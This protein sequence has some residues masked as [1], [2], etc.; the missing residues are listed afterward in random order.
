MSMANPNVTKSPPR[1][2]SP[3]LGSSASPRSGE[4]AA[5]APA[6]TVMSSLAESK[7]GTYLSV[8]FSTCI[9]IKFYHST[10]RSLYSGQESWNYGHYANF[11]RY[12]LIRADSLCR[13]DHF[14]ETHKSKGNFHKVIQILIL[15]KFRLNSGSLQL[16]KC[17]VKQWPLKQRQREICSLLSSKHTVS[18]DRGERT[19][20]V[21]GKIFYQHQN[22]FTTVSPHHHSLS[23]FKHSGFPPG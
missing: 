11:K 3:W 1:S 19:R 21:L 20:Y 5:L 6:T 4:C 16:S 7:L 18:E 13:D 12:Y 17:S 2:V 22:H 15:C 8:C 23:T 9:K 10:I 14:Q